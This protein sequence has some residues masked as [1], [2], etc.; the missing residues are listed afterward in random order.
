MRTEDNSTKSSDCSF[1]NVHALLDN[2][3][4]EHEKGSEAAEDNVHQVRLSDVEVT[5]SHVGIIV[6]LSIREIGRFACR[7]RISNSVG[8]ATSEVTT[9]NVIAKGENRRRRRGQL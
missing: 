9:T 4:A 8:V 2:R 3:G 5:P 1:T 7:Y 6:Y